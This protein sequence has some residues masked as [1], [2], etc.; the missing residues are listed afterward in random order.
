MNQ[1]LIPRSEL[2]Q[3]MVDAIAT[4][5][6]SAVVTIQQASQVFGATGAPDRS[7]ANVAGIVD[8]ECQIAPIGTTSLM[9]QGAEQRMLPE[10]LSTQPMHVLMGGF[11]PQI[12]TSMRAVLTYR[13][14]VTIYNISS[15]ESDSQGVMTRL[16]L[17]LNNT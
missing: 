14:V 1:E 10:I 9:I 13:S 5:L 6:L 11:Y 7:Y 4:G 3:V 12:T 17:G 2:D 8:V 15:V 16:L